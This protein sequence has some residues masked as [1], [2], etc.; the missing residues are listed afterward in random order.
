LAR[1]V[2]D[3]RYKAQADAYAEDIGLVVS[4]D[5]LR[6]VI[7]NEQAFKDTSGNF[8]QL[9]YQQILA[10]N[11]LTEHAYVT[12]L[13]KDIRRHTLLQPV[14]TNTAAPAALV[15]S[16]TNYR[17]ETRTADT[18]LVA[19]SAVPAPP[20]PDDAALKKLYDDNIA[21]FTAPEYRKV[22]ALVIHAT[23]L[24]SPDS[25]D[26]AQVKAYYDENANQFGDPEKRK[27]SQLVFETKE[28]A[29]A[30]KALAAPGDNLA[31]I[32][33]KA[34]IDPPVD[35]GELKKT[36]ALAKMIG[37]AYDLPQGQ[38]SDPVQTDLG[39]HLFEVT[40]ITSG[41]KVPLAM[42]EKT[43]RNT[44]AEDK[45][46]DALYEA[47]TQIDDGVAGGTPLNELAAKVG[48]KIVEIGPIDR[49]GNTPDGKPADGLF[50]REHFLES[51]FSTPAGSTGSLTEIP[52]GY[53]VLGVEK[54][55]PP[56]PKPLDS[57][58]K[59]VLALW[60]KQQRIKTA[61]EVAKQL[62]TDIGP[63]TSLTDAATKEKAA[64][65]AQLGPMTR[66]GE[67]LNAAH[68][69]DKARV[70]PELLTKLF[71]A[72]TGDVVTA[73][74]PTGVVVARLREVT[75]PNETGDAAQMRAQMAKFVQDGIAD[76][77]AIEM[78]RAFAAKFPAKINTKSLETLVSNGS[79]PQ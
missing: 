46:M 40:A 64:S 27:V 6:D 78:G 35:L 44:L 76:D 62:A 3:I 26:E 67:G 13:T 52:K 37:P 43:I 68:M 38:V 65:Y 30:A 25:F 10:A 58:R 71:A 36:D 7:R 49:Q 57:V 19:T 18:L 39:W 42:V 50:D 77:L 8:N 14:V 69:I 33:R 72:K 21:A 41:Q 4:D 74:V 24:V 9:Q 1:T 29:D 17:G 20:A 51:A 31:D 55:T 45:G 79:Q 32:A 12:S 70:S 34:K 16:L 22:N 75:P 63:S 23:D 11:R 2:E 56:A 5:S 15:D 59:D 54:I 48:G 66:L 47:S 73:D 28:K 61:H 60:D 53:Y